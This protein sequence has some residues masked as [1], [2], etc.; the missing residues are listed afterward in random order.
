MDRAA[1]DRFIE[2]WGR[3]GSA[4]GVNTSVARVHALL[5]CSVEPVSLDQIATRLAISRG[6]ASMSLRELR[7]WGVVHL[8]RVPGD[9]RDFYVTEPDVW[10]MLFAIARERKRREF[11]PLMQAVRL[12]LG[13]RG[14]ADGVVGER[15]S[16]M[17]Q[18]VSTMNVL[19]ERL[20]ADEQQGRM[21]L[22][23]LTG[24]PAPRGP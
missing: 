23:L 14:A 6:N 10:K 3:M 19:A 2:A 4:W 24:A 22:A 13:A 5:I 21:M 15:L 1:Q 9:R 7:T 16:Q 11:D 17:D 18:L 20:L 8:Q 12:A